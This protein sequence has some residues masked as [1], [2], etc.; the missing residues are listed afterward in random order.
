MNVNELTHSQQ[1]PQTPKTHKKESTVRL[2]TRIHPCN[3]QTNCLGFCRVENPNPNG[4]EMLGSLF[5]MVDH[6]E[7]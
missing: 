7:G 3:G 2:T 4:L 5:W 1:Q 6:V